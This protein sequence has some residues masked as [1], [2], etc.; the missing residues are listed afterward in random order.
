MDGEDGLG[1]VW[2]SCMEFSEV[3]LIF[4]FFLA[5]VFSLFGLVPQPTHASFFPS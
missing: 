3:D 2:T 5:W 4:F 1:A